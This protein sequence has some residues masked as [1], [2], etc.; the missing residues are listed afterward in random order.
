MKNL[1]FPLVTL[2]IGFAAGYY[3]CH[4][5]QTTQPAM[6]GMEAPATAFPSENS[7]SYDEAKMM[8]DTFGMYGMQ[9]ASHRPGGKG[10]KTRSVFLPLSK[11]DSLTAALDAARKID[12]KTDGMRIYFGRYPKLQLDKSPYK[13]AYMNTIVLVTTKLT[14][15][16]QKGAKDSISIHLD[17]YGAPTKGKALRLMMMD[18]QNRN[19]IC[20]DNC[21]GATL[22]CPDP[23]DPTCNGSN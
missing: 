14:R 2:I 3:L 11:L 17:Y 10:A 7:I 13:H 20:P 8:V 22:V 15:I 18:P 21:S 12:G 19:E 1:F 16:L 6:V 4:S 9:D 5:K 23:T